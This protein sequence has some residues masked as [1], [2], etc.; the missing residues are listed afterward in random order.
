MSISHRKEFQSGRFV[1][2]PFV[3]ANGGIVGYVCVYMQKTELRYRWEHGNEKNKYKL[4]EW[5]AF[6]D[7]VVIKSAVL[8][9]KIFVLQFCG[10]PNCL[11]VRKGRR[12]PYAA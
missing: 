3:R 7:T 4:V 6:V 12:L 10:F 11:D 5:R 9:K 8:R 2:W 1:R